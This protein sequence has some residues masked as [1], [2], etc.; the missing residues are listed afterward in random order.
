MALNYR[1]DSEV[2]LHCGIGASTKPPALKTTAQV[3]DDGSTVVTPTTSTVAEVSQLTS[4]SMCSKLTCSHKE[5]QTS[6]SKYV[7]VWSNESMTKAT[8][9][10]LTD[11]YLLMS[12][13]RIAYPRA[14]GIK[15]R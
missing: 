4:A 1:Y 14:S 3:A 6:M 2:L 8:E 15:Y 12:T 11:N 9:V 7:I 5:T 13:L 10:P